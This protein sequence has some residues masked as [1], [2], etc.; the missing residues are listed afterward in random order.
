MKSASA[1]SVLTFH[2][3][4]Q[5]FCGINGLLNPCLQQ[6]PDPIQTPNPLILPPFPDA[7]SPWHPHLTSTG[8]IR[9]VCHFN[10]TTANH[11]TLRKLSLLFIPLAESAPYLSP[12]FQV[13]LHQASPEYCCKTHNNCHVAG[14][15]PTRDP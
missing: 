13:I 12:G 15:S 4:R 14:L 5:W 2:Q 3:N 8:L 1:M 10:C 6:F 9:R 7:S 11:S